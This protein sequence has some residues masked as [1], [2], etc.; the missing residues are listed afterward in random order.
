MQSG[1]LQFVWRPDSAGFFARADCKRYLL[2][3][4][5]LPVPSLLLSTLPALSPRYPPRGD[6]FFLSRSAALPFELC[7]MASLSSAARRSMTLAS[8]SRRSLSSLGSSTLPK[9]LQ[10][11]SVALSLSA[12]SVGSELRKRGL[13]ATSEVAKMDRETIIRLLHSLGTKNEVERYLRIFTSSTGTGS[14]QGVLP[15]A[16]FAVL[17][18]VLLSFA[19]LKKSASR[20]S[21]LAGP[22]FSPALTQN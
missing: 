7:K 12:S 21:S 17:K 16:K 22:P 15:Q 1:C 2:P 10:P 11:K 13:S 9:A 5:H 18:Y 3:F 6:S 4:L 20:L 19:I 8:S 14:S